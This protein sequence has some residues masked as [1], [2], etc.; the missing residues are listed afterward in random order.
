MNKLGT[1]KKEKFVLSSARNNI[2]PNNKSEI[3]LQIDFST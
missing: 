2:F 1:I 3:I